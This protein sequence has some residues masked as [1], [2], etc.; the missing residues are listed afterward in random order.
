MILLVSAALLTRSALAAARVN[1]GFEPQGLAV[2]TVDLAM[3][4]YTS[5][6]G[7]AFYRDALERVRDVPGVTGAALVERLP[8]S[9]NIHTR[10]VFVDGRS[11]APDSTGDVIDVTTVTDGYFRT[12]GVQIMRGRDFDAAT[13]P[14]LTS[15]III[16]Q[17]MAQRY[18]P[19][20]IRSDAASACAKS[21]RSF[22]VVGVVGDHKVRTIGEGPTPLIHFAR[23]RLCTVGALPRAHVGSARSPR[24]GHAARDA[25]ARA[26]ARLHRE[27][28]HG[29]GDWRNAVSVARPPRSERAS[30][31]WRSSSPA[32]GSTA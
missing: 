23:S 12:L 11:Y 30:A 27:P 21:T 6:R 9:P 19:G 8:F 13:R 28:D 10:S 1:V 2:A 17:A 24:P 14:S 15:V 16:N 25:G 3:H 20:R 31:F 18:W 5:D 22:E 32:S 29:D 4:R 26:A 7:K